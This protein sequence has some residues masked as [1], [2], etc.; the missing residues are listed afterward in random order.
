MQET[1]QKK[2]KVG[3]LLSRSHVLA[4]LWL[5]LTMLLFNYSLQPLSQRHHQ[6]YI[7]HS[8]RAGWF[9]MRITRLGDISGLTASRLHIISVSEKKSRRSWGGPAAP[10][11]KKTLPDRNANR[12]RVFV[13]G[14]KLR[15]RA[16]THCINTFGMCLPA[17]DLSS[18]LNPSGPGQR[19][20]Y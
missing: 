12:G 1:W 14:R 16:A 17:L 4:F 18:L 7:K 15:G 5:P 8:T 3:H 10:S 9:R 6:L 19:Q 13:L 11:K 20:R 2:Y